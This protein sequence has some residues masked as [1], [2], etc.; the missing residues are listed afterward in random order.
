M[1]NPEQGESAEIHYYRHHA[2]VFI[3]KALGADPAEFLLP[4]VESLRPG[5]A[6]LD[7]GCGSGRDLLWLRER[8]LCAEGLERSPELASFAESYSGC[9]VHRGDFRFWNLEDVRVDGLLFSGSLVHL[10]PQEVADIMLRFLPCLLQGGRIYISLKEG[11][12]MEQDGYG[13][14]FH[15]WEEAA[16]LSLWKELG[17]AVC[18]FSRQSSAAGTSWLGW[19]LRAVAGYEIKKG[20]S[21]GRSLQ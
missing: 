4:F 21:S 8:G 18:H 20:S 6:V 15:L 2:D 11:R 3:R 14:C 10:P 12:G 17:L 5:G 1:S 16:G 13:R 7:V 19:V 9:R